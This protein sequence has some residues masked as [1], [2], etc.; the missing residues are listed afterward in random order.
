MTYSKAQTFRFA[1]EFGSEAAFEELVYYAECGNAKM[2]WVKNHWALIIWK[3][4][5][6]VRAKPDEVKQWWSFQRVIDQLKYRYVVSRL[7]N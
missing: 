7:T 6:M 4:A 5:A 2:D 3:T 1:G